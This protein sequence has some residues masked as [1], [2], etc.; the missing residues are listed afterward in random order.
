MIEL[1]NVHLKLGGA[2][3]HFDACFSRQVTGVFGPS[4]AGKTTLLE[5]IAG[6]HRPSSGTIRLGETVLADVGKGVHLPAEKRAI[7][8]VPQDLALFPHLSVRENLLF[9]VG[10]GSSIPESLLA[11]LELKGLLDRYPGKLSG[12]EKQRVAVGRALAT[13][14]CLLL[15]DEPLS[16][17]DTILK[18]KLM[19]L[20]SE[21]TAT[22]QIPVVYV[23]HDLA[24]IQKL[25]HEVA[26]MERGVITRQCAVDDLT[27]GTGHG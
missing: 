8:Y 7:G 21:V 3:F 27:L 20:F 16:S 26:L 4:G 13:H 1:K 17:L 12:G 18:R 15:L 22:L 24:E 19:A 23:S 14:P 5:V 6:L 9:G 2:E 25:C 10:R 11:T